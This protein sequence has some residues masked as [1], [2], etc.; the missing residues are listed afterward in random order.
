MVVDKEE[1]KRQIQFLRRLRNNK[2]KLESQETDTINEKKIK[3]YIEE[4][5]SDPNIKFFNGDDNMENWSM[6]KIW[7]H[8]KGRAPGELATDITYILVE[9]L[10]KTTTK[11]EYKFICIRCCS[12]TN[13]LSYTTGSEMCDMC[14]FY[15]DT[16]Y[17]RILYF[18]LEELRERNV[19]LN[20]FTDRD[21]RIKNNDSEILPQLES[22]EDKKKATIY[23]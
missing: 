1:E 21:A 14:G 7:T 11:K 18:L 16:E 13:F 23:H 3:T 19:L 15:Y 5:I 8:Y 2:R 6:W 4:D 10:E 17:S 9:I 22:K 20:K 12:E